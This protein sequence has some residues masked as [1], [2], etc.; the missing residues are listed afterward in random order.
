MR[1][2]HLTSFLP[3]LIALLVLGWSFPAEARTWF[4]GSQS[5]L[6]LLLWI[7]LVFPVSVILLGVWWMG[8]VVEKGSAPASV[9]SLFGGLMLGSIRRICHQVL[10]SLAFLRRREIVHCDLKP[11]NILL[12][13][14]KEIGV[15]VIDFGSSC[16]LNARLYQ[17]IQSRFYRSP[18]VLL[19]LTYTEA[20]DMWSLGCILVELYTG[21][22]LFGG[23]DQFDQMH[24]I[25]TVCGMPPV[26][27]IEASPIDYRFDYF[28]QEEE[29]DGY[30][31]KGGYRRSSLIQRLGFPKRKRMLEFIDLIEKMLNYRAEDRITPTDALRHPFFQP[32]KRKSKSHGKRLYVRKRAPTLRKVKTIST[33][34]TRARYPRACRK[35]N[36]SDT[37]HKTKMDTVTSE[38]L[39]K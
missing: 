4:G 32:L 27:V 22:P 8:R 23:T 26:D 34:R 21:E 33:Q 7:L 9:K 5:D 31:F 6:M 3:C 29:G 30:T 24:R 16:R 10:T 25:V 28:E 19:G 35:D 11:E 18:E 12:I 38:T 37:C 39:V 15:K 20:I 13:Q 14:P 17:Y 1:L 36:Q 2:T